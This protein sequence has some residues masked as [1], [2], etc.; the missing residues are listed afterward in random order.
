MVLITHLRHIHQL[1]P[2]PR[3]GPVHHDQSLKARRGQA[4]PWDI[5]RYS[6]WKNSESCALASLTS[7]F[8]ALKMLALVGSP[9]EC[10]ALSVKT[11]MSCG[12]KFQCSVKWAVWV[13][14]RYACRRIEHTYEELVNVFG[15]IH[16][17]VQFHGRPRVI[18]SDLQR[19]RYSS[20]Q[21]RHKARGR[22]PGGT[23]A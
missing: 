13:E 17:T 4:V 12:L 1:H 8:I 6:Q 14:L 23:Y 11:I 22:I 2:R 10:W 21:V 19:M 9:L 15:I 16:A 18:D 5:H 20:A 3:R 7:H